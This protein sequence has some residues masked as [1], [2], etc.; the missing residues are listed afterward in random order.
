MVIGE[1]QW[2]FNQAIPHHIQKQA[3]LH[4]PET[5]MKVNTKHSIPVLPLDLICGV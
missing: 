1:L 4:A 5:A 3:L 2:H